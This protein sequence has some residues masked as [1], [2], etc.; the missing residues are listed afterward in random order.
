ML[1]LIFGKVSAVNMR[2]VLQ[3]SDYNEKQQTKKDT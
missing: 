2:F 1:L 3:E